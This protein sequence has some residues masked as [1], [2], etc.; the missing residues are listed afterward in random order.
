MAFTICIKI[1]DIAGESTVASHVGEID[2][3]SW[4]WG[5]T[6]SAQGRW[7]GRGRAQPT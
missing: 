4:N 5:L 2:V 3:L 1:G 7:A 6:Q